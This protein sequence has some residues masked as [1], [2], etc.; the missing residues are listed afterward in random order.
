VDS[1]Y[2]CRGCGCTVIVPSMAVLTD[3]QKIALQR[4]LCRDCLPAQA[5]V[6][7]HL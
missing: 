7:K 6:V 3:V 2:T 1:R 4:R 5:A